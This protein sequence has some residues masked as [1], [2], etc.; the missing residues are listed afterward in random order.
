MTSPTIF[1]AAF[2]PDRAAAWCYKLC[3]SVVLIFLIGAPSVFAVRYL[4]GL[5]HPNQ[6]IGTVPSISGTTSES[7]TAEIF[8][9]AMYPVA[10]CIVTAWTLNLDMNLHRLATAGVQSGRIGLLN[11]LSWACGLLGAVFLI[12]LAVVNLSDGHDV[13]MWSSEAFYVAQVLSFLFDIQCAIALRRACPH[14]STPEDRNSLRGKILVG[15]LT[16]GFSLFFL[17]MFVIREHLDPSIQYSAQCIYVTT[18]YIVV[19]LCFAYPLPAFPEI[20]SHYR[21]LAGA[22][23]ENGGGA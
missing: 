15:L 23:D 22:R 12:V 14:V 20:R 11:T 10:A 21:R 1:A 6:F 8:E 17:L 16:L 5:Y 4:Y 18:E 3:Y 13:H 2:S 19:L 9:W 7:P